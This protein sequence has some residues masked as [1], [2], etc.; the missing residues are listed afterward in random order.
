MLISKTTPLGGFFI[1]RE[2]TMDKR[3]YDERYEHI[4][5][6]CDCDEDSNCGCT[7]P[8]NIGKLYNYKPRQEMPKNSEQQNSA[9]ANRK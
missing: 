6:N 9:I 7:Y 2:S 5:D 4:L 8:N 3:N 1:N